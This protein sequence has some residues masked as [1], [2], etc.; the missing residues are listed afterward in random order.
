M[1]AEAIY[2]RLHHVRSQHPGYSPLESLF[3]PCS[4]E[5]NKL[6][7]DAT[8]AWAGPIGRG[9]EDS[10]LA[11]DPAAADELHLFIVIPV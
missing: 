11:E 6:L 3:I 7:V 1:Q 9:R 4:M 10:G 2:A 8:Q 5:S